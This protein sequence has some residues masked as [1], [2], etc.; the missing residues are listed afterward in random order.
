MTDVH[1]DDLGRPL[2]DFHLLDQCD[3]GDVLL[4]EKRHAYPDD[5]AEVI[6]N[7][8]LVLTWTCPGCGV[9]DIR[10]ETQ[11]GHESRSY[12]DLLSHLSS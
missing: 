4:H 5:G 12:Y 1:L 6:D 3:C 7:R 9:T 8:V 10:Y 2:V 11:D